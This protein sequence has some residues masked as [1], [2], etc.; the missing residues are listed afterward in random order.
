MHFK[1]PLKW[2]CLISD[3][4]GDKRKLAHFSHL[5]DPDAS[6]LPCEVG[7]SRGGGLDT[8]I[9]LAPARVINLKTDICVQ[10]QRLLWE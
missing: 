6:F 8:S 2:F 3:F 9:V 5:Q 1:S 10:E 7:S 4:F